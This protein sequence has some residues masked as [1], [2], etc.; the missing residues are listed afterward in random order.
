MRADGA[1]GE[2]KAV[3]QQDEAAHS[4]LH[5]HASLPDKRLPPGRATASNF[6]ANEFSINSR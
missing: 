2:R 5:G 4:R 6:P 1:W 3:E